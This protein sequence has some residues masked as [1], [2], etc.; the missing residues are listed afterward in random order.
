MIK[1]HVAMTSLN[2]NNYVF[3]QEYICSKLAKI[4]N[5]KTKK[6]LLINSL[7]CTLYMNH[8]YELRTTG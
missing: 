8:V 5:K 6:A 7:L 1:K 4:A 3:H 2:T